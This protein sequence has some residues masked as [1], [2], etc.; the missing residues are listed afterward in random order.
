MAGILLDIE[1]DQPTVQS[2][3]SSGIRDGFDGVPETKYVRLNDLVAL[4]IAFANRQINP[5]NRVDAVCICIVYKRT[6]FVP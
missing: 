4:L 1:G 2:L 6:A 5:P 3:L